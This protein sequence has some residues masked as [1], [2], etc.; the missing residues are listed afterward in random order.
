MFYYV[1]NQ[2]GTAGIGNS[3]GFAQVVES[4]F[5]LETF[6]EDTRSLVGP[7]FEREVAERI[8]NEYNDQHDA[9]RNA[10]N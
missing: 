10:Q 9:Y 4:K 6:H 7:Y 8:R 5:K 3:F 1:E 2:F